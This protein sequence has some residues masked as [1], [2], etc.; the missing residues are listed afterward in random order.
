VELGFDVISVKQMTATHWSPSE[1]PEKSNLPLFLITL[2][3]IS[4]RPLPHIY[5]VGGIQKPE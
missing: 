1:D 2:P 4:H 5:Q 3:R